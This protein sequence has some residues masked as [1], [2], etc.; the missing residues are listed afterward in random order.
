M[1]AG[2]ECRHLIA[3]SLILRSPECPWETVPLDGS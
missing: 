1:V 3:P 2:V